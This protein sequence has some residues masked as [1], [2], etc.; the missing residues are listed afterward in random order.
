MMSPQMFSGR[1]EIR[2]YSQAG[3]GFHRCSQAAKRIHDQIKVKN[4][5]LEGLSCLIITTK[6]NLAKIFFFHLCSAAKNSL[7]HPLNFP[8]KIWSSWW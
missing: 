3:K 8:T 4:H 5:G 2:R 6:A 1:K 7:V